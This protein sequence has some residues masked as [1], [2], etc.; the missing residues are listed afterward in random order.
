MMRKAIINW[1]SKYHYKMVGVRCLGCGNV[2]YPPGKI[3]IKCFESRKEKLVEEKLPKHGTVISYTTIYK[4]TN[5]F[6]HLCP[7]MVAIVKLTGIDLS[8]TGQVIRPDREK[9]NIGSKVK[10][11]HRILFED[12]KDGVIFYGI[13]W[14]LDEK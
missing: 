7:Y 13:K 3:C 1:R 12:K 2:F 4:S 8:V 6:C 11:T 14:R 9:I 5:T 10:A